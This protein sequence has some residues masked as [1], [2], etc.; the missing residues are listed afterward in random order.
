MDEPDLQAAQQLTSRIRASAVRDDYRSLLEIDA[1]PDTARLLDLLSTDLAAAARIH[2]DAAR[3]W[4]LA[5]QEANRRRLDEA[6]GALD[7]FDLPLTRA[8]LSRIEE[9]WLLPEDAAARDQLLLRMEARTME[10]EEL[11][12]RADEAIE[13]HRPPRRWWQRRR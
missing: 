2:L 1:E 11:S 10:T 13:E 6:L 5:R 9:E 4:K 8:L 7:G 12:S 3:R